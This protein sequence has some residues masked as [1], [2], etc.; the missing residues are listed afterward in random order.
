LGALKNVLKGTKSTACFKEGKKGSGEVP[1][2]TRPKTNRGSSEG[3]SVEGIQG[4]TDE[5]NKR[6]LLWGLKWGGVLHKKEPWVGALERVA[7][8]ARVAEKRR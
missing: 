6:Y 3:T 8:E 1:S 7:T 5:K 4:G 2:L